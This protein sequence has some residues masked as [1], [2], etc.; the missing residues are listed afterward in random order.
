MISH[1]EE[2]A[3]GPT[4]PLEDRMNV[5][6]S[7]RSVIHIN[8]N[9]HDRLGNPDAVRLL[10]DK[11]NSIIGIDSAPASLPNAFPVK[12]KGSGRNRVIWASPFCKHYGIKVDQVTAFINVEIDEDGVL[13]LDLRSTT[14]ATR[15]GG[16]KHSR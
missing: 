8:G 5:T 7:P 14:K 6:L 4:Q 12:T 10:F 9:I 1:W 13:R 16:R 2:F 15:P 3:A 11:V